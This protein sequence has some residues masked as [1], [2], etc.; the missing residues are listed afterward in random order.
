M[1]TIEIFQNEIEFVRVYVGLVIQVLEQLPLHLVHL[2]E[3]EAGDDAPALVAVCPVAVCFA[4]QY[5]RG[6]EKP[7]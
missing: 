3:I 1:S 5:H 7:A 6:Y 2:F 4:A